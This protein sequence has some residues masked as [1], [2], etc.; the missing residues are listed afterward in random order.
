MGQHRPEDKVQRE[1]F[2]LQCDIVLQ[3][4]LPQ[5]DPMAP[6]AIEARNELS[7]S[8]ESIAR[9]KL[10]R[11]SVPSAAL[12]ATVVANAIWDRMGRIVETWRRHGPFANAVITSLRRECINVWRKY[13]RDTLVDMREMQ[14]PA[15]EPSVIEQV[16]QDE[17]AGLLWDAL[18][19]LAP[20]E[21]VTMVLKHGY[22][23]PANKIERL[24][25]LKPNTVARW[26]FHSRAKLSGH[27]RGR[28][29][30]WDDF[31]RR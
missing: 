7:P 17:R 4:H 1:Q 29:G 26:N 16:L 15:S 27:L 23:W 3:T 20:M 12:E 21:R 8:F 14:V 2:R 5:L 9:A 10:E 22:E 11:M 25:D 28:D 6:V 31:G 13:N 18:D 30:Y 19:T 24:L